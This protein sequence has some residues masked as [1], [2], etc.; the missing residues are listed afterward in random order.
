[1][2]SSAAMGILLAVRPV[3]R[4]EPL[5][6]GFV[7]AVLR[8]ACA[9]VLRP[10]PASA[11]SEGPGELAGRLRVAEDQRAGGVGALG[12]SQRCGDQAVVG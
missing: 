8:R 11:P 4:A 9:P 12:L 10:R 3:W 6:P 1:M 7:S 2:E 5:N